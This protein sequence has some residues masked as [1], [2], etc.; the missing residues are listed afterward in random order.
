MELG[1][2]GQQPGFELGCL[3]Q[4]PG[5]ASVPERILRFAKCH[6][7]CRYDCALRR[8]RAG[9]AHALDTHGESRWTM[10][11]LCAGYAS[12]TPWIRIAAP[13][14]RAAWEPCDCEQGRMRDCAALLAT[15]PQSVLTPQAS[16]LSRRRNSTWDRS[17][18][19]PRLPMPVSSVYPRCIQAAPTLLGTPMCFSRDAAVGS[20]ILFLPRG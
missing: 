5:N 2:L 13:W 1:R 16:K 15:R 8:M 3:G 9:Y 12:D 17:S 14:M 19:Y 10:Y 7:N 6:G 20:T 18:L 11:W 4:Y